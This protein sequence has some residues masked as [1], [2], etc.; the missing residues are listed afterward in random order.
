MLVPDLLQELLPKSVSATHRAAAMVEQ[1]RRSRVE[2]LLQR[3]QQQ[4]LQ[5]RDL[6]SGRRDQHLDLAG[7][8]FANEP[9][10]ETT[11]DHREETTAAGEVLE[12]VGLQRA[13]QIGGESPD[14]DGDANEYWEQERVLARLL[15]M[16]RAERRRRREMR[17]NGR[18]DINLSV[19]QRLRDVEA[20]V[21][22]HHTEMMAQMRFLHQNIN[23]L[24]AE[25]SKLS[26]IFAR[27]RNARS[28]D[29]ASEGYRWAHSGSAR[30]SPSSLTS[31]KAVKS[32]PRLRNAMASDVA[33]ADSTS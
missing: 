29:Q 27:K 30:Y 19:E 23:L 1:L 33:T 3:Q 8:A 18:A 9:E 12:P 24:R 5:R 15:K 13:Q 2:E 6:V 31:Q 14:E 10:E 7:N 25:V 26:R 32:R 4:R 22:A 20:S 17:N 16:T 11:D 21:A 28:D